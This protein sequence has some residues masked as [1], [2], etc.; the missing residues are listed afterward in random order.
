[1]VLSAMSSILDK[2]Y[3]NMKIEERFVPLTGS[4]SLSLFFY[5]RKISSLFPRYCFLLVSFAFSA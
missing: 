5:I 3:S 2:L 4:T 1:M